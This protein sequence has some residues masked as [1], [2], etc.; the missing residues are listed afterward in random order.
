M[1]Y[2]DNVLHIF[3]SE[4]KP[5]SFIKDFIIRLLMQTILH[6]NI[7][8]IKHISAWNIC[9][10]VTNVYFSLPDAT[11]TLEAKNDN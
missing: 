1:V 11:D 3:C 2:V 4:T 8:S 6:R 7:Y 5:T 9:L 10:Q